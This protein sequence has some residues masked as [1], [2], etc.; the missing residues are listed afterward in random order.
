MVYLGVARRDVFIR[1]TI[2]VVRVGAVCA[3]HIDVSWNDEAEDLLAGPQS[4]GLQDGWLRHFPI[5]SGEEHQKV[6]HFPL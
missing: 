2:L 4:A 1:A 5:P 6:H 3:D